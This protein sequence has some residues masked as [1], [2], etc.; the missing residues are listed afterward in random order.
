MQRFYE[1]PSDDKI[2]DYI[3][4]LTTLLASRYLDYIEYG[5]RH[6]GDWILCLR[7]TAQFDGGL[8]IDDRPGRIYPGA[9][10]SG[11]SWGSYLVRNASWSQLSDAERERFEQSLPF[12]RNS[13]SSPG[14]GNGVWVSDKVYTNGGTSLPRKTFRPQ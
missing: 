14:T 13:A 4:E 9:D 6:A 11:A 5:F 12:P 7:Y 3:E 10:I 8:A 2:N 1:Q